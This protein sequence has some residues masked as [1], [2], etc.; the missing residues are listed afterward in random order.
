VYDSRSAEASPHFT[1]EGSH[2]TY[3]QWAKGPA[4]IRR[5]ERAR[6]DLVALEQLLADHHALDLGSA[7]ADQQQRRVAVEPLDLVLLGVAVA[8]VDAEAVLDDLLAGL[9]REQ[10]RHPRLEVRALAGVLHPRG[11]HRQQ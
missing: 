7:L 8:A 10:L 9:G 4:G 6:L 1:R 5:Y 2:R 11:L 3:V